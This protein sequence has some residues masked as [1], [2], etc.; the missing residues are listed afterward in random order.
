MRQQKKNGVIERKHRHLLNVA[1]T[2]LFQAHLPKEFWGVLTSAYLI[3][4]TPTPLLQGKTPFEKLFNKV[5]NFSH[6]K[7]FGCLCFASTHLVKRTKFDP[8]A[9]KCIFLGYPNG[10]KGY[11]VYDIEDEKVFVSRDVSFFE[12][13]FPFQFQLVSNSSTVEPVFHSQ[14]NSS[15][16]DFG[17]TVSP[18][19]PDSSNSKV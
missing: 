4:R 14:P 17:P 15:S 3:N 1:R 16:I 8:R 12:D 5:P 7:V 10:Q 18:I 6:L 9:T 19:V 2:L 11:K 13:N